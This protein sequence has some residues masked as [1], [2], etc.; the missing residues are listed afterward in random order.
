MQHYTNDTKESSV[1]LSIQPIAANHFRFTFIWIVA[2]VL[3]KLYSV[4]A[5]TLL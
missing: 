3:I 4:K 1:V 5:Y 2:W